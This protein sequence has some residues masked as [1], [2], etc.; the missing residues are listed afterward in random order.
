MKAN[1]Y[2]WIQQNNCKYILINLPHLFWILYST[3]H[4]NSERAYIKEAVTLVNIS[5]YSCKSSN[6]L[7]EYF[8]NLN[9]FHS[10]TEFF[11]CVRISSIGKKFVSFMV[12]WF[13][14]PVMIQ[15]SW[16]SWNNKGLLCLRR[17]KHSRWE[18]YNSSGGL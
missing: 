3:V 18:E 16:R 17:K 8:L 14:I 13:C 11:M 4:F 1:I 7:T 5:C 10:V 9:I 15:N 12:F 6:I 2:C